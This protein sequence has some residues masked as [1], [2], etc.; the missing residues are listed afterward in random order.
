MVISS[1]F[2]P[3][4][5]IPAPHPNRL[6]AFKR[7]GLSRVS[8][9]PPFV[10]LSKSAP[11]A[12][13]RVAR[14]LRLRERCHCQGPG[15]CRG[16][17]PYRPPGVGVN[18]CTC[19]SKLGPEPHVCLPHTLCDTWYRPSAPL[20]PAKRWPRPPAGSRAG[21]ASSVRPGAFLAVLSSRRGRLPAGAFGPVLKCR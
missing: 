19:A 2:N 8:A 5:A 18:I 21:F 16:R 3:I 9:H 17:G 11:L 13:L 12:L 10:A 4:F 20:S 14:L 15:R 6:R 1:I 7:V